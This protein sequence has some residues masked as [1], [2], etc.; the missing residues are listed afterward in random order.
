M[1]DGIIVLK[2]NLVWINARKKNEVLEKISKV[3]GVLV[4]S[5]FGT[6]GIDEIISAIKYCRE[7]KMPLMGICLVM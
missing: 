5:G 1:L 3:D 7:N 6:S 4:P 2:I